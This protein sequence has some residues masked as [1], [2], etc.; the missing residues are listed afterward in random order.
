M[1]WKKIGLLILFLIIGIFI[2]LLPMGFGT[3]S[4]LIPIFFVAYVIL[5]IFTYRRYSRTKLILLIAL[6]VIYLALLIAPFPQCSSWGAFS[7]KTTDCTCIGVER[8]SYG[9][10]DAS[11][12]DCIGIP[13]NYREIYRDCP[14]NCRET[15]QDLEVNVFGNNICTSQNKLCC[16]VKPA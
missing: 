7:G 9:V 12:S 3:I 13:T 4:I 10:L 11:W 1:D 6:T 8:H 15:C 2:T 5:L 14:G 16:A